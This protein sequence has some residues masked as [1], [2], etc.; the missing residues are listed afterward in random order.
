MVVANAGAD[1]VQIGEVAHDHV[2]ERHVLLDDVVL[3]RRQAAGLAQDVVGDPDLPDV[4]EETCRLDRADGV[5]VEP[6]AAG[7]EHG[8]SGDVL[9][10]ALRVAVLRIDREDQA[11]EDV[12]CRRRGGVVRRRVGRHADRVP[13]TGLG[14]LEDRRDRREQGR[15]R[16]GVLGV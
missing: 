7:E 13:T 12:E 16:R 9:R 8:V 14:L 15:R 4:V 5:C 3:R 6:E 1:L 11:L 2:A 10:M